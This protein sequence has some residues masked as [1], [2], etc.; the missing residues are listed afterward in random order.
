VTVALQACHFGSERN[1]LALPFN[2]GGVNMPEVSIKRYRHMAAAAR[3]MA[4]MIVAEDERAAWITIAKGYDEL[5]QSI[6]RQRDETDRQRSAK[7]RYAG[8]R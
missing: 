2:Q 6:E 4:N 5:A 8:S 7:R 3:A 1:S